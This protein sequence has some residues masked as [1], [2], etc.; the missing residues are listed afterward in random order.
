MDELT[1][2]RELQDD[3]PPLTLEARRAARARLWGEFQKP[4]RRQPPAVVATAAVAAAI[5]AA[6]LVVTV[7]SDGDGSGS[8]PA[9]IELASVRAQAV[10]HLAAR[11]SQAQ[12]PVVPGIRDDQFIYTREI[13]VET[14]VDGRGPSETFVDESWRSV[15]GSQPS[16]VS[17]RGRSWIEPPYPAGSVWPP[18]RY[19][20]LEKLPTDPRKL[21]LAVLDWFHRGNSAEVDYESE[22]MGLMFLLRSWRVMPPG[23]QPAAYRALAQIPGVRVTGDEV[24]ARGRHGIG[25]TR[26]ESPLNVVLI[27]DRESYDYL[28]T[29]DTMV[30]KDGTEV[31]QLFALEETGITDTVGVRP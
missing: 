10:L 3:T 16:R 4:K 6:A 25:I 21:R 15:D 11:R 17:E 23:L 9:P 20:D 27:L 29:R 22:Y 24:D 8:R 30:R 18:R 5:V 14:P 31:Q 13:L 2:L 19:D 26:R 1:L 12:G 7:T 28:G